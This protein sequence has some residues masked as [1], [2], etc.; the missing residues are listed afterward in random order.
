MDT[1]ILSSGRPTK[2]A[3]MRILSHEWPL[4]AK[5]IFFALRRS[6]GRSITYQAV[7]KSVKELLEEGVLSKQENQYMINPLW[8]EKSADFIG[9]LMEAYGKKEL[10]ITRRLQELNF[11]SIS[12]A[13]DFMLSKL[14]TGYFGESK[15]VYIQL[16]RFFLFPLSK[17]DI[18]RLK[19][20]SFGKKVYVM[21][22]SNSTIDKLAAG[23]LRSLGAEVITGIECARPTNVI[24]MGN[25]VISLYILGEKERAELS[26]TYKKAKNMKDSGAGLFLTN[27]FLKKVKIKLIIN[28]D[29]GVLS[30]VVEQTKK[31]LSKAKY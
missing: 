3:I 28:R 23:F 19:E 11:A 20:F 14:N 17:E 25:C 27:I 1:L 13:W 12:E 31:I 30:D 2:S 18:V 29:P 26:D 8:L 5:Q 7:Y 21:C 15:E 22:V 10:G 6:S 16:R 4:S 9:G 24:V